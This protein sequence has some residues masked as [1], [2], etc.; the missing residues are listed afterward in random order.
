[1]LFQSVFVVLLL[2]LALAFVGRRAWQA[3]F[4]KNAAGCAKG[5]GACGSFDVEALQRTIEARS[6]ASRPG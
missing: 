1:M 4:A 2:L 5:C 6:A 3:F